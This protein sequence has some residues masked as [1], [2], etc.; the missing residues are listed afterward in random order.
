LNHKNFESHQNEPETRS[1][2]GQPK[3]W[4]DEDENLKRVGTLEREQPIFLRADTLEHRK[5]NASASA[6]RS[7]REEAWQWSCRGRKGENPGELKTRRGV[8]SSRRPNGRRPDE[9]TPDER[10]SLKAGHAP[11]CKAKDA[12]HGALTGQPST[13]PGGKRNAERRIPP[14]RRGNL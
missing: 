14:F 12:K 5:A 10:K 11:R 1:A 9:R 4:K 8:G 7:A 13:K 2:G 6:L 3:A